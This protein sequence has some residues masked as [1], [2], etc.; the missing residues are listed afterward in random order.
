MNLEDAL[1]LRCAVI[2]DWIAMTDLT[3][4]T[5]ILMIMM[6]EET[7]DQRGLPV[8]TGIKAQ[9]NFYANIT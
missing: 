8:I 1:T 4:L 3:K 2:A 9:S 5:V 7:K 6:I